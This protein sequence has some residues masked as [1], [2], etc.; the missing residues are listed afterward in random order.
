MLD[1]L[2]IKKLKMSLKFL[3]GT[4]M[5]L[6]KLIK[7]NLTLPYKHGSFLGIGG[8]YTQDYS[9][10]IYAVEAM[11][12]QEVQI[13]SHRWQSL[14]CMATNFLKIKKLLS[15]FNLA[16]TKTYFFL[17]SMT[18][19]VEVMAF[20]SGALLMLCKAK[21]VWNL[22]LF[23]AL[24]WYQGYSINMGWE[25]ILELLLVCHWRISIQNDVNVL[26]H[27]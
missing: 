5:V 18:T 22:S 17:L 6:I 4:N 20:I 25:L 1:L 8:S 10:G 24:R 19:N 3:I 16:L 21:M 13:S 12:N 27:C 14:W 11:G 9:V 26:N 2:I 7:E 23:L 15:L